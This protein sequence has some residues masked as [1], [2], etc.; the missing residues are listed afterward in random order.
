LKK[1]KPG[2]KEFRVALRDAL[3]GTK[4]L[5]GAHGVINMGSNDHL[6]L[7]QRSRVMVMIKNGGWSLVK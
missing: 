6:G 7:D 5:A 3:E 1:A 4:N 2:T